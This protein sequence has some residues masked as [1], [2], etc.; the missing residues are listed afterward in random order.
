MAGDSKATDNNERTAPPDIDD[1][2]ASM[3]DAIE[4]IAENTKQVGQQIIRLDAAATPTPVAQHAK[5]R[6]Q[7]IIIAR[8]TAG[9]AV[10]VIGT[11]QYPFTVAAAPVVLP[12]PLVIERGTDM[13]ATGDGQVYLIGEPE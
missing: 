12:F 11:A 6:V 2:F 9:A 5:L 4:A 3:R 7:S 1:P 13:S 8:A 10:V